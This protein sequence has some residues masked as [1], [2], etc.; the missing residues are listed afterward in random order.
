MVR[1]V[2]TRAVVAHFRAHAAP[3]ALLA[4]D[5]AGT[6][7]VTA[8][9]HGHSI[10]VFQVRLSACTGAEIREVALLGGR[11]LQRHSAVLPF[12]TK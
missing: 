1:D 2:A 3:L 10:N 8:S 4:W 11:V 6:L 7:L 9:M 5:P 12:V